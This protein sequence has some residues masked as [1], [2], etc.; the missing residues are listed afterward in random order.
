MNPDPLYDPSIIPTLYAQIGVL[1]V[2]C[3]MLNAQLQHAM[4]PSSDDP[5]TQEAS[6][7]AV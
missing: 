3:E 4:T 2:R 1:T 7:A 6:D 5:P